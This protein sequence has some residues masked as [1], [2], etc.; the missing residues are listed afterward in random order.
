[1]STTSL[2]QQLETAA[3][4]VATRV[5]PVTVAIG[6]HPRASGVVVGPG[7]VL[8][9]AHALRDRTTQVTFAD[10]RTAQARALGVDADGDLA[11]L[12]VD[13]GDLA[14]LDWAPEPPGP[15]AIV[16]AAAR[17]HRGFRLTFGSV[18][19]TDRAFR[20]PRGR[21]VRGSVEHTAPLARGSSGGPLLDDAGR[22]LGLNTHRLGE[23]FYLA[24]PADDDLRRRVDDLAAGVPVRR[25][26]LG[27]ALAPTDVAARLR[28]A[29]GLPDREGLLVRGVESGSPAEAAGLREGDLIVAADGRPLASA[30]D[31]FDALEAAGVDVGLHLAVVRGAEELELDVVFTTAEADDAVDGDASGSGDDPTTGDQRG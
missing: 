14:P 4:A 11:V 23:G 3:R 25:R 24:L 8:T 17:G 28:R 7:R 9:N 6:R 16:F 10:G 20:G 18:S 12:E 2:F 19:G 31:L 22:L 21:R 29:V 5:E 27:V 30:D 13:T 26:R 1:M 15:G